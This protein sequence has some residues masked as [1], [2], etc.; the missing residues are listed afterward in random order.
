M[1]SLAGRVREPVLPVGEVRVGGFGGVD[2]LR[3][4]LADNDIDAIVDATHPFAGTMSAHAAAAAGGLGL[5]LIHLRRPGWSPEPADLWVRVA[6]TAAA[7]TVAATL[8]DRV[9]LTIGRQG[10]GAFAHL[11]EPWFLIRAIDP[12]TAALPPR[13]EIL[14]ARGPFTVDDECRLLAGRRIDVLVTKDSGGELTAAKLT[15]ARE[16]GIPVVMIDR[17]PLPPGEPVADSVAA[18]RDWLIGRSGAR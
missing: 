10:V 18:V 6:D 5:P 11:T 3:E 16:R 9:F 15:A 7:A 2:G 12:P 4:W 14:L 8:G 17:P 13:H 1:S